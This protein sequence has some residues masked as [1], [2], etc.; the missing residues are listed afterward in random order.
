M[1][2]HFS[3]EAKTAILVAEV[4]RA[5]AHR[6]PSSTTLADQLLAAADYIGAILAVETERPDAQ[7]CADLVLDRLG[8]LELG[9]KHL[10]LVN[11]ASGLHL[12]IM[13]VQ[14][15]AAEARQAAQ[16]RHAPAGAAIAAMAAT[17]GAATA[18]KGA[19][20]V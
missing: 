7:I 14:R 1:K 20:A 16:A 11:H 17:L 18:G 2:V 3:L 12:A 5:R 9:Q 6:T 8:H 13:E 10:G 4:L 19:Q 15:L